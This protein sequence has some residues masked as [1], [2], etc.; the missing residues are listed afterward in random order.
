[1]EKLSSYLSPKLKVYN[2]DE[3]SDLKLFIVP[4]LKAR[5]GSVSSVEPYFDQFHFTSIPTKGIYTFK[6]DSIGVTVFSSHSARCTYRGKSG[7]Y[8]SLDALKS[9]INLKAIGDNWDKLKVYGLP[10]YECGKLYEPYS[11]NTDCPMAVIKNNW[12]K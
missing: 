8:V 10:D 4:F 7:D 2:G 3:A 1:M 5:G 6:G 9:R 11:K 12:N